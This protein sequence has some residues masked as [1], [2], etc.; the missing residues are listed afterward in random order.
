MAGIRAGAML[1]KTKTVVKGGLDSTP[2]SD[3]DDE[4]GGGSS[5]GGGG[6]MMAEMMAKAR[7]R[8]AQAGQ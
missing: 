6:G 5:G 2:K 8:K 7:A 1:K 3:S 4:G